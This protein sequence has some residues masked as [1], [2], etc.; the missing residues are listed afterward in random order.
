MGGVANSS[1]QGIGSMIGRR[2]LFPDPATAEPYIGPAPYRQTP[3]PHN[4]QLDLAGRILG[5]AIDA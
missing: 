1:C 5:S 3:R 4:S 2:E